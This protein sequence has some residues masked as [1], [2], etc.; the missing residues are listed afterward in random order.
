MNRKIC[1]VFVLLFLSVFAVSSIIVR[2]DSQVELTPAS[3][4]PDDSVIVEGTDF[5]ATNAIAIGWGPEIEIDDESV[6][7]T[8]SGVGP[9]TG[10]LANRP[11]K[12]GSFNMT[13]NTEGVLVDY[14]DN[15][16]GTLGSSSTYFVS[17][18]INYTSGEFNRVSSTDLS[19]YTLIHTVDYTCYRN[20]TTPVEGVTTDG[21][22]VF[23]TNITVPYIWNGT[24][25]VTAID[26]T[27]NMASSD[28]TVVGSD[29]V[30]P[31]P[32][33][34]GAIVLLSSAALVVSFYWLR[35]KTAIKMVKC[36]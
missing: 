18:S 2:G 17:G 14:W 25:T 16:D 32:L 8:G 36:S 3:G 27:G 21:S 4:E 19:S 20:D 29:V 5:A 28:F 23:T 15:G 9:W 10:F 13:S 11:I 26:G 33:T 12:P 22:G 1:V 31:E 35:K 7:V 6:D 34:I 24:E 30:I